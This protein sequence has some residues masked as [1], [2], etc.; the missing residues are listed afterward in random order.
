MLT[1]LRVDFHSCEERVMNALIIVLRTIHIVAGVFWLGGAMVGTFVLGPAV[2]ATGETGRNFMDYL[3]TKAR[4]STRMSGAAGVT[5]LAG[6]I[7]Y[8][9]D[10]HGFTSPWTTSGAG[11]GFG[12]GAILALAGMGLGTVVGSQGRKI[13]RTAA[14][15]QGKPSD[16]QLAEMRAAQ[17]AMSRASTWSTALL[18]LSLVCMAT[19]RYWLF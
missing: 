5:V 12:I 1:F 13:G 14:A 4:L 16:A 8:W 9:I 18:I 7:L 2:A 11:L 15:A 10:S 19:A 17:A 6:A 3:V